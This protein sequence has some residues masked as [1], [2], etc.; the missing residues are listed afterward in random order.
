MTHY[1]VGDVIAN[2]M[3][4]SVSEFSCGS[5]KTV[6]S[7]EYEIHFFGQCPITIS[8]E[9]AVSL[10]E[11]L[12]VCGDSAGIVAD[13]TFI[14]RGEKIFVGGKVDSQQFG[15]SERWCIK[16]PKGKK[17]CVLKDNCISAIEAMQLIEPCPHSQNR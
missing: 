11:V 16:T 8:K 9:D 2:S 3:D 5:V 13:K 4:P 15:S 6:L 12:N 14:E 1:R 17:M 10:R 7:K